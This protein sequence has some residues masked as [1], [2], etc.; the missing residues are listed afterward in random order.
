MATRQIGNRHPGLGGFLQHGEL[1]IER[2]TAT[3]Q[4]ASKDF[5]ACG[6]RARPDGFERTAPSSMPSAAP[7]ELA[8]ASRA[9]GNAWGQKPAGS[10]RRR[11]RRSARPTK[12][13]RIH[14]TISE[15]KSRTRQRI[16]ERVLQW[17]RKHGM[18]TQIAWN[19][20]QNG[21]NQDAEPADAAARP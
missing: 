5:T 13:S 8:A 1:L 2:V 10:P 3:T 21:D 17:P 15:R 19:E 20:G 16:S 4:D 18:R 9:D 14:P 6:L 7:L 11:C 12:K